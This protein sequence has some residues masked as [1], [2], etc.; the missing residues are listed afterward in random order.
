MDFS[1][2]SFPTL[3]SSMNKVWYFSP[4]IIW[5]S[6]LKQWKTNSAKEF[7]VFHLFSELNQF[8]RGLQSQRE[9]EKDYKAWTGRDM[10]EAELPFWV[11]LTWCMNSDMFLVTYSFWL[12]VTL[13][14]F[15]PKLLPQRLYEI[16]S[17]DVNWVEERSSSES[18]SLWSGMF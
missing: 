14:P 16:S 7:R 1:T 11:A 2:S 6:S 3:H 5:F 8:S 12:V 10:G 4:C 9:K 17:P 18:V 15:S 13:H